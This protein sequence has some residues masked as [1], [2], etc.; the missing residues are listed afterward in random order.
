MFNCSKNGFLPGA[1]NIS[2]FNVE[3]DYHNCHLNQR[4]KGCNIRQHV[5]SACSVFL[6]GDR[7]S[8]VTIIVGTTE[9][10]AG[11]VRSFYFC[12]SYYPV[13]CAEAFKL[14][15]RFRACSSTAHGR[16]PD[17]ST[18]VSQSVPYEQSKFQRL[19]VVSQYC[20]F[21]LICRDSAAMRS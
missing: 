18:L 20:C 10:T 6:I 3:E 9:L 15:F 21:N 12:G 17:L 5:S 14:P 19:A 1:K 2:V 8:F 16:P 4:F 7:Q 11:T 13:P